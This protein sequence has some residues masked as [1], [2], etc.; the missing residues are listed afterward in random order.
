MKIVK[1]DYVLWL[2]TFTWIKHLEEE[3][4]IKFRNVIFQLVFLN[5]ESRELIFKVLPNF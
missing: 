4:M 3:E 5:A 2:I 1:K